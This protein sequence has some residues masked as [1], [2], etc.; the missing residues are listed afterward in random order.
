VIVLKNTATNSS[1][2]FKELGLVKATSYRSY[3]N[4]YNKAVKGLPEL[5][6]QAGEEIVDV[7]L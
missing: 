5:F 6:Q 4:A 3:K 2:F 1:V 7:L